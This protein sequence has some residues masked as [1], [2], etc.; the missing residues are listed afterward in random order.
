MRWRSRSIAATKQRPLRS[1][2]FHFAARER[3]LRCGSEV[4]RA[5]LTGTLG[6]ASR[7]RAP[8][9]QPVTKSD[10]HSRAA[11][12]RLQGVYTNLHRFQRSLLD[13][14]FA[15]SAFRRLRCICLVLLCSATVC[16]AE[17]DVDS[18][19]QRIYS[20]IESV[21][22]AVVAIGQRGGTFSGVIVSKE[23]HVL[24]AGHAV[25]PGARYPGV[26]SGWTTA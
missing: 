7:A 12:R 4:D 17:F 23:G 21:R 20:T 19:Q 15:M 24:S 22:P 11:H 16:G 2:D 13:R 8:L 6:L 26:P 14:D 3:D 18:L 10:K 25:R 1:N 5:R 9:S